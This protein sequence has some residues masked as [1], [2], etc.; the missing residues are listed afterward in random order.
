MSQSYRVRS[1][2]DWG[3]VACFLKKSTHALVF[4]FGH[5]NSVWV[6]RPFKSIDSDERSRAPWSQRRCEKCLQSS[7]CNR[8]FWN[9]QAARQRK[10]PPS[11]IE[12]SRAAAFSIIS[13]SCCPT[14]LPTFPR[15][16]FNKPQ[17]TFELSVKEE[18]G[19]TL[20]SR[21]TETVKVWRSKPFPEFLL[22]PRVT[23][24]ASCS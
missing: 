6:H 9:L 23:S 2:T 4:S 11:C 5:T 16:P 8:T 12:T 18:R 14:R 10:N 7:V 15:M 20:S 13:C 17:R 24:L 21:V 22:W 3:K 19:F 1:L